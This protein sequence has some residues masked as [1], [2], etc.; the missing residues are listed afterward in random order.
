LPLLIN[1]CYYATYSAI[2]YPTAASVIDTINLILVN[3]SIIIQE[4][5]TIDLLNIKKGPNRRN[6][7]RSIPNKS[8]STCYKYSKTGHFTRDY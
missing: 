8:K 7:Y 6:N 4:V 5:D 3:T 1:A 2:A